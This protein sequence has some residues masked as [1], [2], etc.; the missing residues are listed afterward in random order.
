MTTASR[1]PIV[2]GR[3]SLCDVPQA[4]QAAGDDQQADQIRGQDQKRLLGADGR[5][6]CR[7]GDAADERVGV[8]AHEQVSDPLV[9]AVAD[10]VDE[11]HRDDLDGEQVHEPDAEG[12]G[13]LPDQHSQRH[14]EGAVDRE[15]E[16]D[17]AEP[18]GHGLQLW[19]G[20][21]LAFKGRDDGAVRPAHDK[22]HYRHDAHPR[23]EH[24]HA[25]RPCGHA[26]GP[27]S[28]DR[29]QGA[30]RVLG[31]REQ[32]AEH[33]GHRRA[34]REPGAEDIVDKVCRVERRER[35][36]PLSFAGMGGQVPVSAVDE[37][38][39][40][41]DESGPDQESRP[42]A[43]LAPLGFDGCDHDPCFSP[44]SWKKASSSDLSNGLSSLTPMPAATSRLLISTLPAGSVCSLMAP[45]CR[46]TTAL[47]NMLASS[48]Y[49]RSTGCALTSTPSSPRSS[50]TVDWV[51]SLPRLI[52]PTR[53]QI[54]ST[55]VSRWLESSTVRLPWP[56]S[57]ISL[58]ISA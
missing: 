14:A 4:E 12:C 33:Y 47:P 2:W 9:V 10:R 44:V 39:D 48:S 6:N 19:P 26:A 13:R 56:M 17:G 7:G 34:E 25:P 27:L 49:A 51:T 37:N 24:D 58:R 52:T 57:L 55:S 38:C 28:E 30:P 16:P 53:S 40:A 8:L 1:A 21:R 23:C 20:D 41:G 5:R 54:C 42:K 50:W 31:S 35:D 36:D 22:E 15:E 32:G 18:L 11:A 29:L 43:I 45:S 46:L 3:S